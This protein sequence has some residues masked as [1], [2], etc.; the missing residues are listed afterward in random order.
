MAEKR[1][2][3]EVRAAGGAGNGEA[4]PEFVLDFAHLGPVTVAD[5]A[6][7]P[8]RYDQQPLADPM[9]GPS[10]GASTAKFYW[11]DGA[12]IINSFAHGGCEYV[13]SERAEVL[14]RRRPRRRLCRCFC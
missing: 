5:V 10:Y 1:A 11:N 14:L 4:I 13:F 6:R 3:A 12:P 8:K 2:R 9:E 7:D